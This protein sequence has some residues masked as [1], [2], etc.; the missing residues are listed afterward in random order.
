MVRAEVNLLRTAGHKVVQYTRDNCEID[1]Y[2]PVERASLA[3][4]T[5]WNQET[6]ADLRAV[7]CKERPDIAH[8]HNFLPL[9]SPAAYYAC[10]ST[11]VPVV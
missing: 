10:R 4:R 7:M 2:G 9:V 3:C 8:C 1:A 5:L 6:Y 11:G